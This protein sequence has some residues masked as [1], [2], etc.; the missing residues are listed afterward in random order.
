VR[1]YD[2][3][4]YSGFSSALKSILSLAPTH[5][6][7]SITPVTP[8]ATNDLTCNWNNADDIDNDMVLN[9]TN[10][11]KNNKS[12]TMLLMPFEGNGNEDTNA[13]DYSGYDNN[14]TVFGA[15][16][17]RT[18]GRVGGR[19]EFDGTDDYIEVPADS[20]LNLPGDFTLE[21]WVYPHDFLGTASID[22]RILINRIDANNAYQ[23]TLTDPA[24]DDSDAYGFAFV[25]NDGGTQ[26]IIGTDNIDSGYLANNWYHVVGTYTASSHAVNLYVNGILREDE[27]DLIDFGIGSS[28]NLQIGRRS[29]NGG[30]FDGLI[31][32]IKIYNHTLS[33]AQVNQAYTAGSTG[34][35]NRIIKDDELVGNE[36]YVCAVTPNDGYLDGILNLHLL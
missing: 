9:I 26:Y 24:S 11:Y 16:W 18:G 32:E 3:S 1:T 10:W 28:G 25:V 7:P 20:T 6:S 36:Q 2:G 13:T 8:T 22:Q 23:L 30:Y 35:T 5:D 34:R 12:I 14:G 21:A 31:D 29:D 33:A 19:Y 17:S 15:T 27:G 4:S